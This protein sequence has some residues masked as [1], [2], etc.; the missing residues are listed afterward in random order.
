MLLVGDTRYPKIIA[1]KQLRRSYPLQIMPRS[2]WSSYPR[3]RKSGKS[4]KFAAQH[5]FTLTADDFDAEKRE[6][7]LSEDELN[8][9]A[10]GGVDF[11]CGSPS[12]NTAVQ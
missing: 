7:S 4:V 10:G 12:F 2:F 5:G 1:H 6:L 9:A 11:G 3:T 8:A